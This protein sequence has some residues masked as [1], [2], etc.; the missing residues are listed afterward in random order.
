MSLGFNVV[1]LVLA[2]S[3]GSLLLSFGKCS[4]RGAFCGLLRVT[5]HPG[6]PVNMVGAAG[7]LVSLWTSVDQI[8]TA[9][10]SPPWGSAQPRAREVGVRLGK[11]G[12]GSSRLGCGPHQAS[13][14]CECRWEACPLPPATSLAGARE[15]A[16]WQHCPPAQPGFTPRSGSYS[17]ASGMWKRRSQKFWQWFKAS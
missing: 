7:T 15:P 2:A 16:S 12:R 14:R 9:V 4:S 3:R 1:C 13:S 10:Q 11:K 5:R 6:G 8:G 17:W